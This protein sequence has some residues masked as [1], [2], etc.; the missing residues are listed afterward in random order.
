MKKIAAKKQRQLKNPKDPLVDQPVAFLASE[1]WIP[2]ADEL[3]ETIGSR[4][5]LGKFFGKFHHDVCLFV[6]G[7]VTTKVGDQYKVMWSDTKFQK[8]P[9]IAPYDRILL[10]MTEYS[11]VRFSNTISNL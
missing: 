11:K 10:G 3:K 8:M 2:F 6:I 7:M 5:I 1:G 4:I 9:G